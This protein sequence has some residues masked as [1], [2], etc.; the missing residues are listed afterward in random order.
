MEDRIFMPVAVWLVGLPERLALEAYE[1]R[2]RF[3]GDLD[4]LAIYEVE[5]L[6]RAILC[7]FPFSE[8]RR[9]YEFWNS[10][11]Q[12]ILKYEEKN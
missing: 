10:L 12:E 6:S 8:S 4:I 5:S 11:R 2:M 9:G 3:N 7:A 1:E